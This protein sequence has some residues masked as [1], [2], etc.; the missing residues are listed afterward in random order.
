MIAFDAVE[1]EGERGAD[2]DGSVPRRGA[3]RHHMR[4]R[5]VQGQAGGPVQGRD[6]EDGTASGGPAPRLDAAEVPAAR[7]QEGTDQLS[8]RA[9]YDARRW[10][11]IL[12]R[13]YGSRS[14]TSPATPASIPATGR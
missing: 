11:P 14:R 10:R 3:H 1:E 9:L 5:R 8:A 7:A 2:L 4:D 13:R 12:C 6:G